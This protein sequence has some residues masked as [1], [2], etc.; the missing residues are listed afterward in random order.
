MN[1]YLTGL[2]SNT[3]PMFV[4][5]FSEESV[6]FLTRQISVEVN[7]QKNPIDKN[8]PIIKSAMLLTLFKN[9]N[10]FDFI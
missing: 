10:F 7:N 8:K 2:N 4:K 9:F 5:Y 1:N 3:L 6:G